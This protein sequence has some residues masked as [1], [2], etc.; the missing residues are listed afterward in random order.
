MQ[1]IEVELVALQE[2]QGLLELG[3]HPPGTVAEGL[4]GHEETFPCGRD[5]RA[6]QLLG[7]AVL[8]RHIEVVDACGHGVGEC[9]RRCPRIGAPEGRTPEDGN[10]RAVAGP[11]QSSQFHEF[12]VVRCF[13]AVLLPAVTRLGTRCPPQPVGAAPRAASHSPTMVANRI[14]L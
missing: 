7:P 12:T 13:T 2:A 1:L 5:Q 3:P 9:R 8:R 14:G 11:T 4:A 10:R 6:E